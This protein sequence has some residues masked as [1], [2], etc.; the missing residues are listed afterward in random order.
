MRVDAL[1][2][3]RTIRFTGVHTIPERRLRELVQTRDRGSFYGLRVALGMVPFVPAPTPHPFSPLV[4][5]QDVARLRREYFRTGFRSATVRY[6][7]TRHETK[8]LL[9]VTFV[10]DEGRA[11]MITDVVVTQRDSLASLPVTK[12]QQKSW[13]RLERSLRKQRGR[14]LDLD[15]ARKGRDRL[16][17]WWRDRGY[18]RAA[19]SMRVR[20][21]TGRSEI[22]LTYR[23][24]PGASARFGEV[25]VQGN[26][27]LSET[28]VRKQVQIKPGTPY[29]AGLL[30]RAQI[31]L[32][33]L[34]IV[35]VASVDVP[36]LGP[37]DTTAA[38]AD[39][40]AGAPI[41]SVLPVRVQVTEA[42][43][44]LVSGDLGY[45]TDAGISSQARWAHRNWS[46]GGRSLTLTGLAQ[47]GWWALVENP[48][49][50]YRFAISLKQPSVF[51]RRTS[52]ALTPFVEHRNDTQ[53]RSTQYG[54][55]TT[56]FYRI[57]QLTSVSLDYQ[58][59]KRKVYEYRLEDLASGEIDLLTFLVQVAQGQLDSL[60]STLDNS[61]FT[62]AGNVS[63]LDDPAN[64][65]RGVIVRP[66]IQVTA[67]SSLSSTAYWRVDAAANGYLP[68]GRS[69]VFST[70]LAL[71]RLFPFGKSIPGPG[72][73]PQSKFLQ[74]RDVAFTAGGT[75]DAR[76]WEN[77]LLGPKV[78]DVRF[79]AVGDSLVPSADSYV[80]LGGFARASFS[81]EL[82]MPL[83][84][85]GPNFGSHVFFGRRP[86]VDERHPIR[87]RERSVR[88]AAPVRRHGRRAQPAHT[89]RADQ[90]QRRIQAQPIGRRSR[91][92]RRR[93]A[94]VAGAS[95]ARRAAPAQLATLAVP[96]GDRGK[97]LGRAESP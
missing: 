14:R 1:T 9:D 91:R 74:L 78:P 24:A 21:D 31:D 50:R 27:T 46:G 35:R 41:D 57:Q 70:R 55:N 52:G 33:E 73:N 12:E 11:L 67:P 42:D 16:E 96:P 10:I 77:R 37:T 83:P 20:A 89:G 92:R 80:P 79:T 75:G 17:K 87:S 26:R 3:V 4:L 25:Q 15:D 13:A 28:T 39:S 2:E 44:H 68:L 71:G 88:P 62:L 51:G 7:V 49:E 82:Q 66:A 93:A 40:L 61:T 69:M 53:D 43:R 6:D 32:Q 60:G 94:G 63:A 84:G 36:A 23:I 97:L 58:I 54:L 18:P 47:T 38:V 90:V 22:R 64:P 5:Q 30:E 59:A 85:F 65:H 95:P 72:D 45:V 19:A 48:D 8:N 29:S 56:L 76:G 86:G 34:D 81:L